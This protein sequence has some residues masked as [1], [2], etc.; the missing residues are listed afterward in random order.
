MSLLKALDIRKGKGEV[1][2][3]VGAGG[4]TTTALRL[5]GEWGRGA[6]FTTTTKILEPIPA[7]DECLFLS[8]SQEEILES[9]PRLLSGYPRIILAGRR[10]AEMAPQRDDAYPFP[11]RA[12]KLQGISPVVVDRLAERLPETLILVEA[13]GARH[14]SLKAPAAYEPVLPTSTTILVPM[15][16]LDVVGQP[17]T[18]ERVH[19]I[20]QVAAISGVAPGQT[21]TPRVVAAVLSHPQ[22]G[23]K[24]IPP[25]AQA[26]P[27]LNQLAGEVASPEAREVAR[28]LLQNERI[29]RV[30]IASL[31]A[32]RPVLEIAWP[33]VAAIVLA[34]GASQRMG[35][36]KQLLPVG[37][38]TMLQHLVDVVRASPAEP[39]VVVLGH[40][41]EE[42][43]VSLQEEDVA[44][45]VNEDWE[46]GLSA[47]VQAGLNALAPDVRA[48]LF[49]LADQ[50][51]LTAEVIAQVVERYRRTRS[52]IV[53]PTY[54]GQR[55]NP[56]LF[57]RALFLE[58]M[59]VKGDQGGR[60]LL[61]RYPSRVEEVAVS[62][63]GVLVDIDT[64]DDYQRLMN[65]LLNGRCSPSPE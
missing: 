15:A 21:V 14:R 29:G 39:V 33:R 50:P 62:S 12:N 45:V 55:G 48:A 13:D 31:R 22:G 43:R 19:R 56:V 9:V 37:D 27:I 30:V 34:A 32:P 17:L 18:Q 25:G 47:S 26:I 61:S 65:D 10:L 20:E 41:A 59:Q 35:R 57:D 23:L 46:A 42:M 3:L 49:V 44:I 51:A 24:G 53:V 36:P 8:E 7:E 58:L 16:A 1:I 40:R 5:A 52:P 63:A 64:P 2:A 11:V 6:I 38:K 4:K 60:S 28:L 54:R